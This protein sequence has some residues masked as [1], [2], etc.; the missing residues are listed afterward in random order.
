MLRLQLH[1]LPTTWVSFAFGRVASWLEGSEVQARLF[2][3]ADTISECL[4]NVIGTR[5]VP[6]M[7]MLVIRVVCLVLPSNLKQMLFRGETWLSDKP[8]LIRKSLS[9]PALKRSKSHKQGP[10]YIQRPSFWSLRTLFIY[11]DG[12]LACR[13]KHSRVTFLLQMILNSGHLETAI[14][15]LGKIHWKFFNSEWMTQQKKLR[16]FFKTYVSCCLWTLTIP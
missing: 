10:I 7:T 5:M 3:Q 13:L 9:S 4:Y 1:H 12:D 6:N 8:T 14:F 16:K 2:F 11:T 15:Q